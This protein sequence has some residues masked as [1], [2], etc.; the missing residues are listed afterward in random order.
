MRT[1]R[2]AQCRT[3]RTG[4]P[5]A[6]PGARAVRLY[7][8]SPPYG[9]LFFFAGIPG[10]QRAPPAPCVRGLS[11][12]GALTS[13]AHPAPRPGTPGTSGSGSTPANRPPCPPGCARTT[14]PGSA[15]APPP[16]SGLVST[17]WAP[18]AAPAPAGR[19]RRS[20]SPSIAGRFGRRRRNSAM[21]LGAGHVRHDGIAHH[22]IEAL[23]LRAEDLQRLLRAR[24]S[25]PARSR[26]RRAPP[27]PG[28][29]GSPRHPR[30]AWSRPCTARRLPR[31]RRRRR[32][33]SSAS[34]R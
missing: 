8:D 25:R 14:S 28:A 3:E 4:R 10:R 5:A 17:A 21:Q 19:G 26:A 2:R 13:P 34:G 30:P 20:R 16:R 22:R 18:A 23:R 1:P 7:E 12:G 27:R 24:R 9:G 33:A 6:R 15:P 11:A 31:H 29:P 32:A